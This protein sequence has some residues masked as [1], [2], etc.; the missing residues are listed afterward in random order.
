MR[1]KLLKNPIKATIRPIQSADYY[2]YGIPDCCYPEYSP[3]K[4]S[5]YE[6][7]IHAVWFRGEKNETA[8]LA[9]ERDGKRLIVRSSFVSAWTVKE[10]FENLETEFLQ[11]V[12]DARRYGLKAF[13]ED[14]LL[15]QSNFNVKIVSAIEDR[16]AITVKADYDWELHGHVKPVRGIEQL[17]CFSIQDRTEILIL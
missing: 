7:T 9:I 17:V 2:K 14:A 6:A 16:D 12:D 3:F 10:V 13:A 5:E 8:F 15:M 4:E 1:A 11:S